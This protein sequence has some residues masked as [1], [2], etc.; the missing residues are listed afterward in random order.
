MI[1]EPASY[2]ADAAMI[3]RGMGIRLDTYQPH[4]TGERKINAPSRLVFIGTDG[5]GRKVVIKTSGRKEER[6]KLKNENAAHA[7][8]DKVSRKTGFFSVPDKVFFKEESGFSF[9]ATEYIPQPKLLSTESLAK[10]RAILENALSA[11]SSLNHKNFKKVLPRAVAPF[12]KDDALYY[13]RSL[14][15]LCGRMAESGVDEKIIKISRDAKNQFNENLNV[16]SQF[17]GFLVHDDFCPHNFRVNGG[18]FYILD[19]DAVHFGNKHVSWARLLNYMAT[20]NFR[21]EK[22]LVGRL[23][24]T[25]PEP[26]RESLRLMR[27]Y[28]ALFLL[29]HYS[30]ASQRASGNLLEL[31]KVRVDFWATLLERFLQNAPATKEDA[32]AYL[33]KRN[34]FRSASE[35][36]RQREAGD[37]I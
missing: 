7:I 33:K 22:L 19:Y 13:K 32:E 10:Q 5:E 21:L 11:L 6:D 2:C 28:K 20:H 37:F 23:A 9:F 1:R 30:V 34:L 17:S 15:A 25:L 36:R 35:T 14:D 31:M 29:A 24:K 18:K 3:I 26:E 4:V 16:V 8:L 12:P 27:V